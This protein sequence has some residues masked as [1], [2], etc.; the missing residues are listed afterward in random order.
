MSVKVILC[1]IRS[2]ETNLEFSG[3]FLKCICQKVAR[4]YIMGWSGSLTDSTLRPDYLLGGVDHSKTITILQGPEDCCEHSQDQSARYLLWE[5]G[6]IFRQGLRRTDEW[7]NMLGTHGALC[8]HQAVHK[9]SSKQRNLPI[10]PVS[11][12]LLKR[13]K[14]ILQMYFLSS[15]SCL[16]AGAPCSA[17]TLKGW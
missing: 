7:T 16:K 9:G 3:I 8:G 10:S 6:L 14:R 1:F 2:P 4:L 5:D 11:P 12:L 17:H 15:C 13:K